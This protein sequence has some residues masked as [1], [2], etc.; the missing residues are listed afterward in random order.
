MVLELEANMIG[1]KF[2]LNLEKI[3]AHQ[4]KIRN[5]LKTGKEIKDQK[6]LNSDSF[7][8]HLF[9]N[10]KKSSKYDTTQ[11]FSTIQVPCLIEKQ[12][13]ICEILTYEDELIYAL[14]NMPNI[15][16]LVMMV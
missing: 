6:E 12:S 11:F 7:Y 10:D 8:N 9:K 1:T 5:I 2:S 3:R 14:K 13:A 4:N 16:H 15:N